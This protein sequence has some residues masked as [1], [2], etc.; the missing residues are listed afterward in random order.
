MI[1]GVGNWV[2][3]VVAAVVVVVVVVVVA[4]MKGG[5]D[6][7]DDE[8]EEDDFWKDEPGKKW[9]VAWDNW[10]DLINLPNNLSVEE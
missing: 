8:E 10:F 3:E 1:I 6:E 9:E 7:D 2:V 4:E 5:K